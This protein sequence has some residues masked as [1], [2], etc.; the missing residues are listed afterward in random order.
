MATIDLTLNGIKIPAISG[1]TPPFG[2]KKASGGLTTQEVN[3]NVIA[4]FVKE[5]PIQ[6]AESSTTTAVEYDAKLVIA[7]SGVTLG[8]GNGSYFGCKVLIRPNYSF[9]LQYTG[10]TGGTPAT[11]TMS[12][13]VNS[14][15]N[16]EMIWD[17]VAWYVCVSGYYAS[18][19]PTGERW[20][21]GKPIYKT[22]I[23]GTWD[24]YTDSSNRRGFGGTILTNVAFLVNAFGTYHSVGGTEDHFI[25]SLPGSA[26]DGG[27]TTQ[28]DSMF[29]YNS[30]SKTVGVVL[31]M[32][33]S[34]NI[35]KIA[36]TATVE[37]TKTTS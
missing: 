35:T 14:T 8:M 6:V 24:T 37:H 32:R 18:E 31:Q 4:P 13:T 19:Q 1:Y 2:V 11:A 29:L 22:V 21:D 16:I 26:M 9:T 7:A 15:Q 23:E 5:R 10:R 36:Y 12:I 3:D 20:L 28:F 30:T 33:V 25:S 34:L 17:G 27:L